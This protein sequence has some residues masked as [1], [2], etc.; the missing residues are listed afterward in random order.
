[1]ETTSVNG[2]RQIA[3]QEFVLWASANITGDENGQAHIFLDRLFQ[4]FGQKGVLDVGGEPEFRIRKAKE[5]GGGVAFADL[6]WKPVVLIEMKRRGEKLTRHYRQA[7]DYWVRLVPDRPRYVVLCNFDEF[8]I[9]DFANQ[10]DTPVDR[11]SLAELPDRYDPLAFLFPTQEKPTFGSDVEAVTRPVAEKLAEC[12]NKLI[13]RQVERPLAQRFILRMLV[14]L[15]AEDIG[16]LKKYFVAQL[17]DDC[18]SPTDSYDLLG[19]LFT[20]M[21]TPGVTG[22][23]RF[24]GVEYFNGGLFAEPAR[25]ELY[26]DELNQLRA[27]ANCDWSKISPEVFGAIFQHSMDAKERHTFGAHFTSPADIMKIV[28]PTIVTPWREL[29]ENAETIKR[30]GQLRQR[31]EAFQVLDPACGS[32][33]FLYIAYREMKRLEARIFE[34]MNELSKRDDSRQKILGFVTAS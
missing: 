7:F 25:L 8:W 16:L 21:N 20:E 9:Y 14:A 4:A 6:V 32:G 34:R 11:V 10:M 2:A 33:N 5:D 1:M 17:L 29:I 3:L 31:L 18:K 22:G 30:L 24:K 13:V 23:G 19:A 28:I 26:D 12:F 15:F 27:C